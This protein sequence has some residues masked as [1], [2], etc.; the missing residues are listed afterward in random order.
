MSKAAQLL[1]ASALLCLAADPAWKTKQV[2]DWTVD[3]AKLVL[4]DSPWAASVT[5]TIAHPN[6]RLGGISIGLPGIGIGRGRGGYPPPQD[7]PDVEAPVL[8]LRWESALPIRQAELKAREVN[9]PDLDPNS[10]VIAVYGVP[11]RYIGGPPRSLERQLKNQAAIRRDGQKDLKP[12]SVEIMER[13]DGP[14]VLYMF[15]RKIEIRRNDRRVEFSAEIGSLQFTKT[16][17][18]EDM[19]WQSKLEL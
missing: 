6:G 4:S 17:Y 1:L 13:D 16:F 7:A 12:T 19:T 10:Y 3:D 9:A 5:T 11:G 15:P 14:L 2:A 8:R 18:I